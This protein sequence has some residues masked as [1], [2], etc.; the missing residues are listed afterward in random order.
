MESVRIVSMQS[1]SMPRAPDELVFEPAARLACD[2]LEAS[3]LDILEDAPDWSR[4]AA[5]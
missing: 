2:S 1:W 3:G 5:R 4:V